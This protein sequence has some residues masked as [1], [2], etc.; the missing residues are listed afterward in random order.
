MKVR[1][2]IIALELIECRRA[3][4]G[5]G[6]VCSGWCSGGGSEIV[7]LITMGETCIRIKQYQRDAQ[8]LL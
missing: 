7:V 2:V 5:W 8:F 3:G 4:G 6:A 1:T